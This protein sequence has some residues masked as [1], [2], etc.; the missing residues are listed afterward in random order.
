M[1]TPFFSW[2]TSDITVLPGDLVIYELGKQIVVLD[3]NKRKIGLLAM[4]HSPVAVL[5]NNK[6]K[7]VEQN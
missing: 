3:L 7:I 4:G 2:F 6:R 1:A 5:D